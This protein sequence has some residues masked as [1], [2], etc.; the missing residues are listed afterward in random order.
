MIL[1]AV[2]QLLS[3]LLPLVIIAILANLIDELMG[4][5]RISIIA[6]Y[7]TILIL[8]IFVNSWVVQHINLVI[9]TQRVYLAARFNEYMHAKL[10]NTD[11]CNLEKPSFHEMS[12]K[13]KKFLYGDGHGFSYVL[14]SAFSIV[15]KVITLFGIIAIIFMKNAWI[16][17]L[18]LLM[19]LA[20]AFVDAKAKKNHKIAMESVN[21][22]RRWSYFS[23]ILEDTS[24]SKEI[25]MNNISNWLLNKEVN[26]SEKAIG[27]YKKRNRF[28]SLSILFNA[29]TG[30][31]QND[32]S[33]A[34][35]VYRV[36][37]QTITIGGFTLY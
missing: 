29:F 11:F 28:S 8:A 25:R 19:I 32:I 36:L 22:E 1:N 7:V 6:V 34:Y 30:L 23:Q 27:F 24:Y 31:L 18:F 12:E 10:A 26:Y 13:A 16:V 5:Q 3:D 2:N 15:G 14:E 9:F 37:M 21:V 17:V 4:R 20:S 33:Y 35:L